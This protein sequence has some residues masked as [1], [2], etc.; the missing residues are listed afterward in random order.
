[1]EQQQQQQE[2]VSSPAL[3][4]TTVCR[5]AAYTP[6]L[7]EPSFLPSECG[8][9]GGGVQRGHGHE[10]HSEDLAL[11]VARKGVLSWP[12]CTWGCFTSRGPHWTRGSSPF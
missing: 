5:W 2:S 7:R 3:P 8:G 11:Q 9:G 10:E 12:S 1:M 6:V 4:R